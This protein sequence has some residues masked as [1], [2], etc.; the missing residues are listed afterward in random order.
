MFCNDN[1]KVQNNLY[2]EVADYSSFESRQSWPN[3]NSQISHIY[4]AFSYHYFGQEYTN[5]LVI[6]VS[7]TLHFRSSKIRIIM[8]PIVER[9]YENL[10][11]RPYP[12][13][14]FVVFQI[15]KYSPSNG[16]SLQG[17]QAG[18]L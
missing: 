8:L 12:N 14:E 11:K 2:R 6:F 7:V 13:M 10:S 17:R 5:Y 15:L 16:M 4:L 18:A 1:S 9:Q 3:A